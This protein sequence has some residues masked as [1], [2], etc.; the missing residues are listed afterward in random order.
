MDALS[1]EL[2]KEG[3]AGAVQTA[4]EFLLKLLG[5]AT[6]EVGFLLQDKVRFYRFKNQLRVLKKAE[7]MLLKSGYK[8]QAVPLRVLVPILEAAASEDDDNL[9]DKWAALLANS[10]IDDGEDSSHPSFPRILS[11][12]TPGEAR[13]LDHLVKKGRELDWYKFR[14]ELAKILNV[15]EGVI[16]F[17]HGNLFRLGL[18][19]IISEKKWSNSSTLRLETFGKA[20][21]SACTPPKEKQI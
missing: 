9:S 21:M 14:D 16:N 6:E 5:P 20:F 3:I 19:V 2:A 15:S 10:S 18:I 8:P 11:D 1:N 12:I 13:F 4:K 17:Y 7:T